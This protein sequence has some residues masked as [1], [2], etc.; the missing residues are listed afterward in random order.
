MKKI[1][2]VFVTLALI[3]SLALGGCSCSISAPLTFNYDF[4][5]GGGSS[6]NNLSSTYRE[7]LYYDVEFDTNYNEE[8]AKDPSIPTSLLPS[9]TG[10]FVS[11]FVGDGNVLPDGI[12]SDINLSDDNNQQG[13]F[14]YLKTQLDLDV[15]VN[16]KTFNDTVISEVY[17]YSAGY[18]FAP[19]YAKTFQK[20]TFISINVEES[21]VTTAQNIYEY[22]TVYNTTS[23]T[24]TKKYYD[25]P[26]EEDINGVNIDNI[27]RSKLSDVEPAKTYNYTIKQS[28][29][30]TQ[31]LFALRCLG[32]TTSAA[33]ALP[34]IS[35]TYGDSKILGVQNSSESLFDVNFTAT[36]DGEKV[37]KA[38]GTDAEQSFKMP[39]KKLLYSINGADFVGMRQYVVLQRE[40]CDD[41]NCYRALPVEYAESL[42]E[43]G[44][45]SSIGALKYSLTKMEVTK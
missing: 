32:V 1:L 14:H 30:N 8:L 40:K 18:S 17:F 22:T 2:S 25:V 37:K 11:T 6:D 15:T 3:F 16:G 45:L 39:V 31:L 21:K 44:N 12:T 9:Y 10:T 13:D 41:F 42:F 26:K 5:G 24:I 36:I 19:V 43:Y 34:T 35:P 20:N 29:D 33:V 28:I 23:Y 38:D 27:D 4:N 7:V